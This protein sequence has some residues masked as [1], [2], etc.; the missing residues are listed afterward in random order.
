MS[1]E[2]KY[3]A[4]RQ[5]LRRI[6]ATCAAYSSTS[7]V[8]DRRGLVVEK[9]HSDVAGV[10][11]GAGNRFAYGRAHLPASEAIAFAKGIIEIA[12]RVEAGEL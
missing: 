1:I 9:S 5:P 11:I 7:S 4:V 2:Y 12:R 3:D 10:Y 6:E 8:D